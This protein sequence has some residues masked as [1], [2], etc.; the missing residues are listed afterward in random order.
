MRL[1][2]HPA[3]L[4]PGES[5]AVEVKVTNEGDVAGEETAFLFVRDPVASI[6]RPLL[7]LRGVAK[8]ALDRGP[9]G[10]VRFELST[11]DL[12][13]LGPTFARLEPGTFEIHVGPSAAATGLLKTTVRLVPDGTTVNARPSSHRARLTE[14][15]HDDLG[16]S[17]RLSAAAIPPVLSPSIPAPGACATSRS[18]NVARSPFRMFTASSRPSAAHA[19]SMSADASASGPSRAICRRFVSAAARC[20]GW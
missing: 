12:G 15:Q 10:T 17:T 8:L 9:R 5:L 18:G 20:L 6:A 7:E 3:E 16:R 13:F 11:N 1:R 19:P 14:A 2:A 4:R